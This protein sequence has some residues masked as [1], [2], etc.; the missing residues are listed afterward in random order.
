MS[1]IGVCVGD[2][3]GAVLE[4]MGRAPREDEVEKALTFPGGGRVRVGPGQVT[5]DGEL[6]LALWQAI[7]NHDPKQGPPVDEIL[8]AYARWYGSE[9]F[10]VGGTCS[11]AFELAEEVIKGKM[12]ID[13]YLSEVA[14]TNQ[15]SQANG[16]LMRCSA[17]AAWAAPV[18]EVPPSMVALMG[19]V[20]AQLSHPNIVCQESNALYLYAATLLLRGVSPLEA[21]KKTGEFAIQTVSS[22]EVLKWFFNDSQDITRLDCRTNNGHVRWAFCLAFYFLQ[23]PEITFEQALRETLLKGGDTDT[24]AAIVGGLV[25]CYQPVPDAWKKAVLAF[26]ADGSSKPP[27][28]VRPAWVWP[29]SY[30]TEDA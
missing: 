3:A 9:P 19:R 26:R 8:A 30:F 27:G 12:T 18:A 2:A 13:A 17:L 1:I 5:D 21:Y 25:G 7:R 10:D 29:S 22:Q 28:H 16:S 20:D 15:H 24:N 6:T 4:F 14:K 23:N 11:L